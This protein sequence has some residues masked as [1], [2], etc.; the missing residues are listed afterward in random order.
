MNNME[1]L[2]NDIEMALRLL[3]LI[4]TISTGVDEQLII[5]YDYALLHSSDF[6]KK[7]I[8]IL[9]NSPFRKEE[10]SI[11]VK[12]I[13]N[14]LKILAQKQLIDVIYSEKGIYYLNNKLTG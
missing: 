5:F 11:K 13:K 6:D 1:L 8:S 9:P 12:L 4:N 10:L 2:N 7:Q 14:A 3:I